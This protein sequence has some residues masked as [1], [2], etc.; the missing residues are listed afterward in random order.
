MDGRDLPKPMKSVRPETNLQKVI[1]RIRN[2]CQ[3]DPH[4]KTTPN[5]PLVYSVQS[6]TKSTVI[7]LLFNPIV[8][9]TLPSRLFSIYRLTIFATAVYW[10]RVRRES[11]E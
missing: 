11:S 1:D 7:D 4:T 6:K 8:R 5:I 3:G 2:H 10:D 9:L